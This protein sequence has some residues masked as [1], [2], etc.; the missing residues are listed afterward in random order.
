MDSSTVPTNASNCTDSYTQSSSCSPA[1]SPSSWVNFSH[2]DGNLSEPCGPNRTA[3]G[4]SDSSCPPTGSP[5][6][7]TAITI[8]ALYSIVCVV[9]L[10]GNFLVMYVIVRLNFKLVPRWPSWLNSQLL[11][12]HSSQIHQNEDCHQYLHFQPCPSGCLSNQYPALPERQ[13]P[14]GHMA[15]WNH[16]LQDCDLHR[17]L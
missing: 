3:L 14:N 16:P 8:M 7:I 15:I 17:L 12:R 5:S 2:L 6:M 13:L 1:P 4:G 9:G 10:F 11:A